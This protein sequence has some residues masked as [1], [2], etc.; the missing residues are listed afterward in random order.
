MFWSARSVPEMRDELAELEAEISH[1][2]CRQHVLVNELDKVNAAAGDGYRS[3]V[4][5]LSAL[6]DVDGSAAADLVNC[7]R[8]SKRH[9]QV[10]D[11]LADGV[12]S[13]DRTVAMLR[14]AVAGAD[15]DTV[16]QSRR[17]DLAGEPSHRAA[18][19]GDAS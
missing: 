15:D 19:Q 5:W 10:E 12:I 14:L 9:R 8:W 13:F 3:S 17:L 11:L 18:T 6:L 2:R 1:L 16:Q 4:D 7:A